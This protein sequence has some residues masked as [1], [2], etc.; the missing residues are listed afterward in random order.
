MKEVAVDHLNLTMPQYPC[1]PCHLEKGM[2]PDKR[3]GSI[4]YLR[5][6]NGHV[7]LS[8]LFEEMGRNPSV[9]SQAAEERRKTPAIQEAQYFQ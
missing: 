2:E 1:H 3:M 4:P 8:Y 9:S 5:I 7:Q 6:E